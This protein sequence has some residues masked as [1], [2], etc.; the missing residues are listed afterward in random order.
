MAKKQGIDDIIKGAAKLIGKATKKGAKKATKKAAPVA[1]KAGKKP[2]QPPKRPT[3]G[4]PPA[5]GSKP[6]SRAGMTSKELD[7][8]RK[9][10][11]SDSRNYFENAKAYRKD[12]IALAKKNQPKKR[13][14]WK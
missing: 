3:G 11:Y 7:A 13:G 4:K 6:V 14:D 9:K 1:K 10:T 12:A 2:P 5:V 8:Y